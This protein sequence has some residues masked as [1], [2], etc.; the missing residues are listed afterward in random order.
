MTTTTPATMSKTQNRTG[1]S[2]DP[3]MSK[4]MMKGSK[5]TIDGT[6]SKQFFDARVEDMRDNPP[7]ATMPPP[8]HP[9]KAR[10]AL[11]LDKLGERLA[12]ERSGTRLY[13]TLILKH[14]ATGGFPGGP[15]REALEQI[16]DDELSHFAMLEGVVGRFGGDPTAVT[17]S[18]NLVAVESKGICAAINDPRTN[19]AEGLHAILVAELADNAGWMQLIELVEAL[20]EDEL[21]ER[22]REALAAEQDHLDRVREW[23]AVDIATVLQ[24]E[25]PV[26]PAR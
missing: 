15:T 20:G 22:F 18:A 7:V 19:L 1:V 9:E 14:D 12:F 6:N 2:R 26:S 10:S 13:E 24:A 17:P 4:D 8:A 3:D 21:A 5:D 11:L 25:G 23:L 16:R